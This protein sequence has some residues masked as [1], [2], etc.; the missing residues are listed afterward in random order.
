MT[1]PRPLHILVVD[2]ESDVFELLA[3]GFAEQRYR[4]THVT[5]VAAAKEILDDAVIDVIL[6]D[7]RLLNAVGMMLVGQAAFGVPLLPLPA[8]HAALEAAIRSCRQRPSEAPSADP[9]A[10]DR[11]VRWIGEAL[12]R[13]DLKTAPLEEPS[14][15]AASA[16]RQGVRRAK[17]D[18]D[19]IYGDVGMRPVMEYANEAIRLTALGWQASAPSARKS[20]LLRAAHYR[21]IANGIARA[22]DED[23]RALDRSA[24]D[25]RRSGRAARQARCRSGPQGA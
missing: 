19:S 20:L 2:A 13:P 7:T 17:A 21:D 11:L 10:V 3:P 8:N 14:T 5:S 25:C 6:V 22:S 9:V 4:I 12:R 18:G 24:R 15:I 23:D 16:I 1:A